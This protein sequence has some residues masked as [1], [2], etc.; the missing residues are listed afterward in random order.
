MPD[1]STHVRFEY[2]AVHK[3]LA[4]RA[5]GDITDDVLGAVYAEVARLGQEREV[6][7][8]FF[9][10]SGVGRFDVSATAVRQLS[11]LSPALPDPTPRYVVATKAHIFGMARMFQIV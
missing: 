9:D 11:K 3:V 4:V 8:A 7:A 2:D 1:L 5:T 10:L 6:R